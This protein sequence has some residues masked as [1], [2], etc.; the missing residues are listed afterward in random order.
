VRAQLSVATVD[1]PKGAI[2]G[3]TRSFTIYA[4][5]QLMHS[6]DW[7]EIIVGYQNSGPVRVRD[8]GQAVRPP[9][10]TANAVS[11]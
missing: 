4:N 9:G 3:A 5:D 10:P 8:I 2:D 1:S 7:N 11:F 6:K